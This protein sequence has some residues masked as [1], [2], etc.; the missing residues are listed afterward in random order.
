MHVHEVSA[1]SKEMLHTHTHMHKHAGVHMHMLC[2]QTPMGQTYW[3]FSGEFLP[4]AGHLCY[5]VLCRQWRGV[6]KGGN[7]CAVTEATTQLVTV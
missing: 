2:L 7:G 1:F 4:D 3:D 5:P 6:G